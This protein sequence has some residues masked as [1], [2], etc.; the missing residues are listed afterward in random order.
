MAMSTKDQL[1]DQLDDLKV[2]QNKLHYDLGSAFRVLEAME[3][4]GSIL[5][6]DSKEVIYSGNGFAD[7]S[8]VYDMAECPNCGYEYEQGDKDWKEPYCPRCG[9]HL[10]WEVENGNDG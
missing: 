4:I 5:A 7:G 9:Q 2:L 10:D 3:K 8:M 6:N 1:K